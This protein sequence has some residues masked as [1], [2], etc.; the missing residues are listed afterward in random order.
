[1]TTEFFKK[2]FTTT[3]VNKVDLSLTLE[4]SDV[5]QTSADLKVIPS[6]NEDLLFLDIRIGNGLDQ[7]RPQLHHGQHGAERA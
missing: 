7:V 2:K 1:M 4:A 3:P 5:T 6:D